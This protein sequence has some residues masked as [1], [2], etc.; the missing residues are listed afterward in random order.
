MAAGQPAQQDFAVIEFL[1]VVFCQLFHKFRQFFIG[2]FFTERAVFAGP[3][4]GDMFPVLILHIKK[5]ELFKFRGFCC[6]G[7]NA[8]AAFLQQLVQIGQSFFV[9]GKAAA[10]G[11]DTLIFFRRIHDWLHAR[12]SGRRWL[13]AKI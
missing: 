11:E 13:R 1:A 8:H 6:C 10:P 3:V 12:Q 9:G 2:N 5:P 7:V 4:Q